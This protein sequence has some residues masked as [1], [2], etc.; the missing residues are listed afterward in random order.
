MAMKG[1]YKNK[2]LRFIVFNDLFWKAG[3][4]VVGSTYILRLVK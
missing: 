4:C 1:F 2:N 3:F